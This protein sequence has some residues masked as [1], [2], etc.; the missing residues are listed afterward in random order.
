MASDPADVRTSGEPRMHKKSRKRLDR[1][2]AQARRERLQFL[3]HLA[4]GL[5]HEIRN[6]LNGIQLNLEL[7]RQ[8]LDSVRAENRGDFDKKLQRMHGEVEYLRLMVEEF[9]QFARP[10]QMLQ[11]VV[12]LNRFLEDLL[13]FD[14]PEFDAR[15]IEVVRKFSED[16]YP[17]VL[18]RQQ[19]AQVI[20]NLLSNA[21]DAI[22][23]QGT[24]TVST[25]QQD[26]FVEVAV[27]D[28]GGGVREG[29]EEKIFQVFHTGKE[30]GT[31]LGL[32]IARRIVE[33]HG[34]RIG[35]N[36]RPGVGATFWVRLLKQKILTTE[37]DE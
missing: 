25:R 21:R 18:D 10:P 9:L 22:G 20:R 6:P 35:L 5:A 23:E 28:N 32:A 27:T 2:T 15:G 36:N 11:T 7:L 19:F 26:E 24:I 1:E 17:V 30:K 13:E 4:S 33:E 37:G 8:D 3:G 12:G 29:E 16:L 14:A 31:G 34:G